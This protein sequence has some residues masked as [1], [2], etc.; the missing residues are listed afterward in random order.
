MNY[1]LDGGSP[2]RSSSSRRVAAALQLASY[3]CRDEPNQIPVSLTRRRS[4]IMPSVSRVVNALSLDIE[5]MS[6]NK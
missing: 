3:M 6:V 1:L 2:F 5:R 4:A